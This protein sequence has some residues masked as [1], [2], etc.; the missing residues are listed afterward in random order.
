MM[1]R[2]IKQDS[3]PH[4]GQLEFANVP[5]EGWIID[6]DV[7]GL[8]NGPCDVVCL[9]TYYGE[10]FHTRM[11]TCGVGMVID[12]RMGPEIF[13]EPFLKGPCRSP[14]VFL[15]T[16]SIKSVPVDY[17]TFLCD[18]V[19]ILGGHQEVPDSVASLEISMDHLPQRLLKPSFKSVV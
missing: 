9:P 3:I 12:G 1:G 6:P 16:L 8:L 11:M 15:I 14:C 10:V 4:V 19:P 18:V 17:S 5:I 2:G 13:P 7:H